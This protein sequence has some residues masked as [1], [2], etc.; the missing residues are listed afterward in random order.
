MT[1][2]LDE[3][4]LCE[5]VANNG[6][7]SASNHFDNVFQPMITE[8]AAFYE[9]DFGGPLQKLFKSII[10]TMQ[11]FVRQITEKIN[12]SIR[13]KNMTRQLRGFH[14]QLEEIERDPN[15]KKKHVEMI[16]IEKLNKVIVSST[17]DLKTIHKRLMKNKYRHL[18]ELDKD[19]KDFN[20]IYENM[21]K[22]YNEITDKKVKY[23]IRKAIALIEDEITGRKPLV[24]ALNDC[25]NSCEEMS[26]H[27]D[28]I[29]QKRELYGVEVL[30]AYMSF[31]KRITTKFTSFIQRGV[32]KG[33]SN[34]IGGAVFLLA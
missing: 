9:S 13:T 5:T 30:P 1:T 3:I 10:N 26:R 27:V 7:T 20:T 4:I 34:L 22:R 21:E 23:P 28:Q 31:V 18:K 29:Q 6:I 24:T 15:H 33:V 17:D 16:D 14:A 25:I 32:G 8:S 11:N 2:F 19:I 12:A